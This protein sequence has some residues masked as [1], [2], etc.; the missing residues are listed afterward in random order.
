MAEIDRLGWTGGI[1]CLSYG[2]RIGVR[3]K[4]PAALEVVLPLL[5][6]RWKPSPSPDV[7]YLFSLRLGGTSASA[8]LRITESNIAEVVSVT[9]KFTFAHL[10]ELF[11]SAM[12]RWIASPQP[13][14]VGQL[15]VIEALAMRGQLDGAQ[16]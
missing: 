13:G 6:P 15:L 7:D 5:P 12:L 1:A 3:V 16:E 8:N 10:K 11:L 4:D 9:D 2:L 14:G